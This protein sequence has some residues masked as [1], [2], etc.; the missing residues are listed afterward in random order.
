LLLPD[1]ELQWEKKTAMIWGGE[2]CMCGTK[3]GTV[4]FNAREQKKFRKVQVK[5]NSQ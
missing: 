5:M 3:K 1:R 2:K 4:E